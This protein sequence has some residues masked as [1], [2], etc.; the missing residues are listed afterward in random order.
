MVSGLHAVAGAGVDHRLERPLEA[1]GP[2][3]VH[4]RDAQ[5][6]TE[7]RR[8]LI[9]REARRERRDLEQHAARLAEVDRAEVVAV[10]DLGYEAAGAGDAGTPVE[11]VLVARRPR[12]VVH[13]AR[14]LVTA[15]RV[16][17]VVGPVEVARGAR[18]PVAAVALVGESE[19]V[20]EEALLH[21]LVDAVGARALDA[22][23]GVL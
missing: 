5:L 10:A 1:R 3:R 23:D 15:R 16:R 11:M 6:L 13:A 17:S 21:V 7:V 22:E 12:D 4:L 20:G 9:D 18:E 2:V 19:R 8:I 14:A